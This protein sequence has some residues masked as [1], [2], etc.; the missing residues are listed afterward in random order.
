MQ[1]E[2]VLRQVMAYVN[3][4]NARYAIMINGPWGC[5]KTYLYEKF[6][7]DEI[8]SVEAG[9]AP[10]DRRYNIYISLYGIDSI[11]TLSKTLLTK[12]IFRK[13]NGGK[14][15]EALKVAGGILS[16]TGN[17]VSAAVSGFSFS[18]KDLKEDIEKAGLNSIKPQKTIICFDDLERSTIPIP[19]IMG[20]IN[21]LVEHSECKVIILA[22]ESKIGKIY[23]NSDVEA[24]YRV[25]LSGGRR[26]IIDDSGKKEGEIGSGGEQQISVEEL[27]A[28][29]ER[30]FSENYIYRDIKEKVVGKTFLYL[31]ILSDVYADII[32]LYSFNGA[33]GHQEEIKKYLQD[34]K[35][36]VL[37][38]FEYCKCN[39]IRVFLS[40]LNAIAQIL[41]CTEERCEDKDYIDKLKL[42]ATQYSICY[43][44]SKLMNVKNDVVWE[45]NL[46]FDNIIGTREYAGFTNI[47]ALAYVEEIIDLGYPRDKIVNE[48]IKDFIK[49]EKRLEK[50]N[51]ESKGTCFR[52]ISSTGWYSEDSKFD[53]MLE[54]LLKEI[55]DGKYRFAEYSNIFYQLYEFYIE[56][57]ID[58]NEIVKIVDIMKK[59]V[60]NNYV[61]NKYDSYPKRFKSEEQRDEFLKL[62]TPIEQRILEVIEERYQKSGDDNSVSYASFMKF[63][64][65]SRED[66]YASQKGLFKL[67]NSRRL[68]TLTESFNKREVYEFA[69]QID[70]IYKY[71]VSSSKE[72]IEAINEYLEWVRA[73]DVN[74]F[75]GKVGN[76]A[77]RFLVHKL[78]LIVSEMKEKYI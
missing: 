14:G 7:K 6:L 56:E 35:N 78:E 76:A 1:K 17:V 10:K 3:D 77:R 16:A 40:W 66:F 43:T 22:D 73:C 30:V 58:E 53:E 33:E 74:A 37:E 59:S 2:D 75:T 48:G 36:D 27:K 68:K 28:S 32:K 57:L 19:V 25:I 5:G 13:R 60:D 67:I 49:A 46:G 31:P 54:D 4:D 50:D 42:A 20:Y 44:C 61:E 47:I 65:E 70:E 18:I 52:K 29:T 21:N 38:G 9:K 55:E 45:S 12:Y 24:K 62:Y 71:Y 26:L 64:K 63:I 72:D 8:A 69:N 51:I 39:N 11:E 15:E 34:K 41:V 23:A